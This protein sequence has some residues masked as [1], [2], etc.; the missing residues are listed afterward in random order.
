MPED[1]DPYELERYWTRLR[2][3]R[4][5]AEPKVSDKLVTP[6]RYTGFLRSGSRAR[7]WEDGAP[8]P[9]LQEVA[10][11]GR[12]VWACMMSNLAEEAPTYMGPR[13][14]V[15]V[16]QGQGLGAVVSL[17]CSFPASEVEATI[18]GVALFRNENDVEPIA[19]TLLHNTGHI[20]TG[21]A[22]E[23]VV[24]MSLSFE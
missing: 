10:L 12:Y 15:P 18:R 3:P 22:V 17:T 2:G 8:E 19:T 9:E 16:G 11:T 5:P 20:L 23:I 24:T 13:I 4:P 1:D 21:D 14:R 6:W 7:L